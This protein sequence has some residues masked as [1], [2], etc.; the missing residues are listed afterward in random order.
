MEINVQKNIDSNDP[1]NVYLNRLIMQI[2]L[3]YQSNQYELLL[4]CNFNKWKR[5]YSENT[6]ATL[7]VCSKSCKAFKYEAE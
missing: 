5:K 2:F 4:R 1:E 6:A 3:K 7:Q